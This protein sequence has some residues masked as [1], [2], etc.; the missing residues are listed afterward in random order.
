MA[1]V[2]GDNAAA[3]YRLAAQNEEAPRLV[4]FWAHGQCKYVVVWAI[5]LRSRRSP[6]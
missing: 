6:R 2:F 3:V 5:P 4:R 1:L